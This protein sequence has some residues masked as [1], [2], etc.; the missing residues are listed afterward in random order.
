MD[1]LTV[2]VVLALVAGGAALMYWPMSLKADALR[3]EI[4][5]HKRLAGAASDLVETERTIDAARDL[6]PLDEL[7]V[8]LDGDDLPGPE[9]EG[10]AGI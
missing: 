1:L 10:E 7:G 9:T 3:A 4:D 5:R 2:G 6:D 8:L